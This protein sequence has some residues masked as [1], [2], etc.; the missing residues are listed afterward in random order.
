LDHPSGRAQGWFF[1]LS[2]L[3]QLMTISPECL[4]LFSF[5]LDAPRHLLTIRQLLN[6]AIREDIYRLYIQVTWTSPSRSLGL[7]MSFYLEHFLELQ[8]GI[9]VFPPYM[10][11]HWLHSIRIPLAQLWVDSHLPW[12]EMD[13]YIPWDDRTCQMCHLQ[14]PET[15]MHLI[16]R[17]PL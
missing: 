14:E 2:Q 12:I 13:C 10:R 17:C 15:E 6:R 3:L 5:P 11:R 7:K 9:I 8:D 16:F 4:P 1:E